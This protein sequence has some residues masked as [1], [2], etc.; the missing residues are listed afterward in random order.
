MERLSGIDVLTFLSQRQKYNEEI[1]SKI[2]QQVLD[3]IE[4]LHFRG[5]CLLE[6]QPDNVVMIDQR[7]YDIKLCDFAN[8]R[9]VP[10]AGATVSIHGTPEYIG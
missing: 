1:V 2:I 3:G 5:I 9:R 7:K 8:A 6:L 10:I 4:Y